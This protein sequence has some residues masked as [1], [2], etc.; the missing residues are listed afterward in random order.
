[1]ASKLIQQSR[2]RL[3]K[4]PEADPAMPPA[5]QDTA[6][7][8]QAVAGLAPVA[9]QGMVTT[10]TIPDPHSP[11]GEGDLSDK[12][13][14]YLATCEAAITNLRRA[15]IAAGKALQVIRDGRLYRATHAT[16][17]EYVE[18]TWDIGRQYAYK[19]I[20][21]WLLGERLSP[22]GDNLN[23]S[24]VRVLLPMARDHGD[25]AAELVYQTVA[26]ADGVHVTAD[27]LRGVVGILPKAHFD[28]D[29]AVRQI[30]AYLAGQLP[31]APPPPPAD[32]VE[33]LRRQ[34]DKFL[35][36]L[37]DDAIRAVDPDAVD[38]VIASVRQ[39]LDELEQRQAT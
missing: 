5:R 26:D 12:E 6:P 21:A 30:R 18:S 33:G 24:Q 20:D 11:T 36:S 14:A 31:P 32:P 17:E 23:E 28:R 25:D 35:T 39:V 19:L 1:V 3:T 9:G 13:K 38:E 27:V 22:I 8:V 2:E 37:R 15:F 10:A 29:E 4:A 34:R 16:F 7:V